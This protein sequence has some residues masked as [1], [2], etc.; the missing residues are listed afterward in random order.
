[1]IKSRF[2]KSIKD[3]NLNKFKTQ[4]Q[5]SLLEEKQKQKVYR[6]VSFSQNRNL[7]HM[8]RVDKSAR[9]KKEAMI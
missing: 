9:L 7:E 4:S 8:V 3:D 2:N 5:N 6:L 1:M